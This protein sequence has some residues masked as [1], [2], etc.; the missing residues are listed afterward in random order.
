LL[1]EFVL[2]LIEFVFPL[3]ELFV[4]IG[5]DVAAGDGDPDVVV[6]FRVFEFALLTFPLLAAV[7]QPVRPNASTKERLMPITVFI[8]KIP[9][10]SENRSCKPFVVL[11]TP[12]G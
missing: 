3:P 1:P 9:L 6:E 4:F 2:P 8:I 11:R 5:V 7:S 12:A 10:L